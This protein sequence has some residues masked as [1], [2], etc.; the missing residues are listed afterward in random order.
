MRIK[1]ASLL[2]AAISFG[3]A[4]AVSAA[5]MPAK[6]PV[7]KA[8]IAVAYNWTGCY[9]GA[10]VGGV[11]GRSN[12][13][14]PAYPANFDINDA[15]FL[16]GGQIGCNYQMSQ[17]V[18]GVEG[19]WDWMDVTGSAL[20]G[21]AAA[22]RYSV[23]W[24]WDVSIRGRLGYA[25]A[26]TPWLLYITGGPAWAKLG[27]ANFIPGAVVTT[28]QSGT[29]NGWTIGAGAEYQ[30]TPNWIVGI[31]YRYSAYQSKRYV[32]AGPVDVDLKTNAVTARLSY[33]FH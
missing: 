22:E 32:Y 12:I 5:D 26:G 18:V 29:H 15:S 23:R 13:N 1:V 31:E 24:D 4:Q 14:I 28:A 17:F 9:V 8:P 6:A 7:Y 19:N 27:S 16:G 11:W 33:L 21:A 3:A 2:A 10:N 20:T 25:P 30:W